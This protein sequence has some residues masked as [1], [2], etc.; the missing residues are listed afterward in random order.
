MLHGRLETVFGWRVLVGPDA[1]PR[2]LRNFG[3]QAN[4]A[5]MLRLACCLATER[6]VEVCAPVHD[7][8]LVEGPAGGIEA[9]VARTQAA[10]REASEV[11]R[12][13]DRYMD[14]R[15]RRMW[16]AVEE[17]LA[18]REAMRPPPHEQVALA[19]C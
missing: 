6:G 5:E 1:N 14:E 4:G 19:S 13:P 2:S 16:E 15:G 8:L 7:A 12:H 17:L 10:M 9:V 3:M 18:E 11:V